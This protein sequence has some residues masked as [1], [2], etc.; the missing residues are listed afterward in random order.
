[1]ERFTLTAADGF[2]VATVR[3][4]PDGPVRAVLHIVHGMA[5]YGARYAPLAAYLCDQGFAVYAHD[6][7]GHGDSVRHDT[8]LGH[9]ADADGWNKVIA[10]LDTVR[11]HLDAQHPGA[12]VFL[13]GHSMGSFIVRAWLTSRTLPLVGVILSATGQRLGA[14]NLLLR[15]VAS[16]QARKLGMRVASRLMDRLVYG[17]FNLRFLPKRTASDWLSRDPAQVDAYVADPLCGFACTGQLWADLLGGVYE[18][19]RAEDRADA[20]RTDVPLL[21]VAGT[22]DPVSFGGKGCK[23]VAVRYR[24]AGHSDVTE[25]YYSKGRHELH[26]ETNREEVWADLLAWLRQHSVGS[27]EKIAQGTLQAG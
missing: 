6:H 23:Q 21:L 11:Q 8:P 27:P 1:M 4:L 16:W 26:N 14:A 12:P 20:L 3:W 5:E 2:P 17:S 13:F 18:L 15:R 10:D 22:H 9:Y 7:R 24:R 25:R 19:E